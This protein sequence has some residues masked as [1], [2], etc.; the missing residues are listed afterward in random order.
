MQSTSQVCISP[1]QLGMSPVLRMKATL[2]PSAVLFVVQLWTL[3]LKAAFGCLV[4]PA[5]F[6]SYSANVPPQ[7]PLGAL[8]PASPVFHFL[9][10]VPVKPLSNVTDISFHEPVLCSCLMVSKEETLALGSYMNHAMYEVEVMD[11]VNPGG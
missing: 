10:I 2:A 9:V 11:T 7:C 1:G 6:C 8:S 3:P 5:Q 4:H